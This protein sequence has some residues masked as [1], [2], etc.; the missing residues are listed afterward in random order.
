[1]FRWLMPHTNLHELNLDWLIATVKENDEKVNDL[2]Q[3]ADDAELRLTILENMAGTYYDSDA[4]EKLLPAGSSVT[5]DSKA[6]T[7][8]GIYIVTVKAFMPPEL[9]PDSEDNPSYTGSYSP[10][11][12]QW[13]FSRGQIVLRDSEDNIKMIWDTT[14]PRAN[15]GDVTISALVAAEPGDTIDLRYAVDR[16]YASVD[17][18]SITRHDEYV[19]GH[20]WLMRIATLPNIGG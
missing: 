5:I 1:M 9:N 18:T 4:I 14:T 17:G 3:W 10:E 2:Q 19:S 16:A 7:L 15:R 20:M 11:V 12:V 8:S 13:L 6:V